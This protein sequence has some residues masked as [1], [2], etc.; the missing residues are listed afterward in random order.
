MADTFK[1]FIGGEWVE[2]STGNYFENRNPARQSDLIGMWPR[3]GKEDVDRAAAAAKRAQADWAATPAPERGAILKAVGDILVERKDDIARAATREMGKVWAETKGDVQEGIDTA[4]Y[5]AT[6]GR[7]L[8]GRTVPSELRSKWAMSYRRPIGVAGLIT[9][10]NFPLAIPTWKMF[11]ALVCGNAVVIKPGEDVPHTVSLLVEV[12]EEAG[13]PKG[14]VNLV[15]GFG[16][17]VGSHIVA[18]PD[19]PVISFTGSTETGKIIGRVCGEMH[20]RLSLEMGGKNAQIV[21]D[22]ADLELALDGVLWGA[23]GTTGQRCTA[24]SRL[25]LHDAVHDAFVERLVERARGLKLGYGN[26]DGVDVGPLI[27]ADSLAKVEKY[28]EIGKQE[29]KLE[30]GGGRATGDGLDDGFFFEPTIFTG[31]KPGSRMATEEIF[32]PVLSVIRFGDADEAFRINNEVKYGLSSSVYTRDVNLSFRAFQELDN[33]ITYV[34]APT[35]GAEAHLP[36]GG[37]KQTGNGHRE[38]GWEVYEFYSE[39][40]VCYLDYSGKLQR[41]QIDNYEAS[42]Y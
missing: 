16:D 22:D 31:I 3:S 36:F 38:G 24:T 7:Q 9:P 20:K 1:N 37:V 10:F 25:L 2:P 42:P 15:H 26:D 30:T 23:F 28:V 14:V 32:G 35:I 12:L 11:P 4:Y 17:E 5:A 34:N 33:G 6:I 13:I 40:K 21:M 41:A 39:T 19:I 8:F 29:G 27:N 18:H